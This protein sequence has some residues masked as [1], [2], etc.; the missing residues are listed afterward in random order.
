MHGRNMFAY[1]FRRLLAVVPTLFIIVTVAFFVL[2]I[3]PGG[4]FDQE[5]NLPPEVEAKLNAA[6]GLDKPLVVQYRNYLAGLVRGDLGPSY[7]YQEFDVTELIVMALPVSAVIGAWAISLAIVA[8][9]TLGILAALRRDTALDYTILGISSTGLVIP[10]FVLAPLLIL[11]LSVWLGLLPVAGLGDWR[12]LLLPVFC[13]AVPSIAY[14]TRLVRT[15]MIETL[16]SNYVRTARAKG[17]PESAVVIRHALKPALLPV[18][19]FLGPAIA[20]VLTG[21]VVIEQIFDIPGIGRYFVQAALN[22]DYPLVLGVVIVYSTLIIVC[23][24]LADLIYG[25]LDPRARA[26]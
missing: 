9:I 13:L 7:R 19:S 5:L 2:R 20:G 3:I 22:R 1:A 26:A 8:G 23:N 25:W 15:G 10:R 21:S 6:Y 24:F 17:L 12:H 18:V 14:V 11:I 16:R 4:P